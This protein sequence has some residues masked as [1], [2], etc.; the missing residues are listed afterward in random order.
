MSYTPPTGD[1]VEFQFSGAGYSQLAGD[2][3]DFTWQTFAEGVVAFALPIGATAAGFTEVSGHA[4]AALLSAYGTNLAVVSA[5]A[6]HKIAFTANAVG[7]AAPSGTVEFAIPLGSSGEGVG[8][9]SGAALCSLNLVV[10]ARGSGVSAVGACTLP[11]AARGVGGIHL[12][13]TG[14]A[15]IPLSAGGVGVRGVGGYGNAPI[16]IISVAQGAGPQSAIGVAS[17]PLSAA[18][19]GAVGRSGVGSGKIKLTATGAGARGNNGAGIATLLRSFGTG[20]TRVPVFGTGMCRLLNARGAGEQARIGGVISSV[21]VVHPCAP[22]DITVFT[23][24]V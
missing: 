2:A 17:I 4:A 10:T 18:A 24:G 7:D 5:A 23:H 12:S 16:R 11:F 14:V 1:L 13:G 15:S 20:Q 3:V 6:R 21:F 9:V 19:Q 8:P 22:R